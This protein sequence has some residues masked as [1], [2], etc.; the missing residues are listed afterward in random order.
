MEN[1]LSQAPIP[2][3]AN[4][5]VDNDISD[6]VSSQHV[7]RSILKRNTRLEFDSF[8]HLKRSITAISDHDI[9]D[10]VY[11]KLKHL[12]IMTTVPPPFY[13]IFQPYFQSTTDPTLADFVVT[14]EYII[15]AYH[16]K[17]EN[18]PLIWSTRYGKAQAF[19]YRNILKRQPPKVNTKNVDFGKVAL[20]ILSSEIPAGKKEDKAMSASNR[21]MAT[22]SSAFLDRFR[23][24]YENMIDEKKW[25]LKTGKV[26]EDEIFRHGLQCQ[27]EK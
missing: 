10:N 21:N 13:D 12:V 6:S 3:L 14:Y 2:V 18:L 17:G 20:K 16:V 7:E 27:F 19:Y 22:V 9:R 5:S 8:R 11:K 23:K 25:I 4:T 24:A 1:L 15:V 26:V